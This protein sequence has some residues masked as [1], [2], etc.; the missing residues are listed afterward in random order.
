MAQRAFLKTENSVKN[1]EKFEENRYLFEQNP[2][3]L[4]IVQREPKG[5]FLSGKRKRRGHIIL[6]NI[7]KPLHSCRHLGIEIDK[8]L[9]FIKQLK[10]VLNKMEIAIGLEPLVRDQIPFKMSKLSFQSIIL[11]HLFS[12]ILFSK[13]VSKKNEGAKLLVVIEA[14]YLRQNTVITEI[15]SALKFFHLAY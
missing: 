9:T 12:W 8:N 1:I 7:L 13:I 15:A 4:N 2:L 11:L 6:Q 14:C 10:V 5:K 3:T